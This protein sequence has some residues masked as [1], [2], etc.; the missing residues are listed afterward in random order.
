MIYS[1]SIPFVL[2]ALFGTG[3]TQSVN[4]FNFNKP[5]GGPPGSYFAA[6]SSIPVTA[7]QSA[8]ATA[9]TAVPDGTYPINREN[10][11]QEVT[12]HSDW[13]NFN[14]GAAYVWIAD[15]DVDCDGIDYMCKEDADGLNQTNFGALA[16]YEVP[17]FVIPDR[18]GTQYAKQLPGNN[19]GAVICDGKMFYGVY[20]DSNG[21]TPQVI[22]EASWLMARTCF[23]NDNL[24]GNNGHGD[25]D[26]TY[27]IFTGNNSV[28]PSSALNTSYVTNFSI[29]R[30]MGDRLVTSLAQNLGLPYWR[31]LS[32]K[33]IVLVPLARPSMAVKWSGK[34]GNARMS[35][36]D[37]VAMGDLI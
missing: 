28:L 15:M 21:A 18:F 4:G 9:S 20:G 22:G 36:C 10:G 30:S 7:L 32:E 11:A 34:V 8:A 17:F 3:L 19:I 24:N 16:A 23:P 33:K 25:A 37:L 5:T 1:R 31:L 29:L 13:A 14:Q 2:F 35:D 27:I 6:G 12:I 26:V